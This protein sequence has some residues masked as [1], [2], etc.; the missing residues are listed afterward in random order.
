MRC[1]ASRLKGELHLYKEKLRYE[2]EFGRERGFPGSKTFP[3]RSR[4]RE[5][6]VDNLHPNL[7]LSHDEQDLY[8]YYY[9]A[10]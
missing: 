9:G 3:D 1:S 2:A 4:S 7:P 10:P 6:T 5:G 8:A